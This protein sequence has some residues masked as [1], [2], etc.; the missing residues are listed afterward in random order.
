VAAL[1]FD[2]LN[3][4]ESFLADLG[5]GVWLMDDHRWA[6]KVWETERKHN[7]Y[8]LVHA[9]YHWDCCYDFHDQPAEEDKLLRASPEQLAYLVA[10]GEWIR[11]D[12]FIAPAVKRGLV[13]TIHFYCL[14]ESAGDNALNEEF[15]RSCGAQQILHRTP[16]QLTRAT[17]VEPIIFDLCLDLFNRSDEW[18]KG[19]LWTDA[20]IDAFVEKVGS[21]ITAAELVTVSMSFNYSGTPEQ[22][23]H[24]TKRV[25]P[26]ILALRSD[27]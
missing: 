8:S 3:E 4:D 14:Q 13:H 1:D 12:S 11:Y 6:L 5:Y 19:D 15:L 25:I 7:H 9:D 26:K 17:I 23:R 27:A 24:L 18:A 2:L 10:H 20:G 21:L 22:T 16:D